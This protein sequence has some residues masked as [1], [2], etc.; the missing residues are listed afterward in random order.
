MS[1]QHWNTVYQTKAG[2]A[3]SWYEAYPRRSVD[4]IQ[5]FSL[6]ADAR[7][8][9]IG[10]G[11]SRLVDALLELNF[12]NLTVLDISADALNRAKARLGNRA[13]QVQ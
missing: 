8:I 10:G 11:D 12:T 13:D 9:D 1:Q 2:H 3:V 5:A 7:I 4:T 6:P